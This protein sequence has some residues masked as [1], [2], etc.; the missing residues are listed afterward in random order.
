MIMK[1]IKEKENDFKHITVRLEDAIEA[2]NIKKD[3]IYVDCTFGRGGHSSLILQ[4]LETGKLFCFDQDDEAKK[5][6]YDNFKNKNCFF[7]NSNFKNLKE[8][9]NKKNINYVDG[10]LFDLGVSSPMFDNPERGFSYKYD[11]PLDMRMNQNQKLTAYDVINFYPK[12][13][14]IDIFKKY[15][16]IYNSKH[17]V[18]NICKF[19][20]EKPISTTL[21]LVEIIRQK[22]PIKLQYEKKHFARKYFQAIRIE[23]NDEIN[24][25]SQALNDALLMLNKKGRIVTISF[26]SLEEK[27]IKEIINLNNSK[28]I[29]PKEIPINNTKEFNIIKIKRRAN[30]EELKENRRSRSSFLKVVERQ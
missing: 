24:V 17:V 7:I 27:M 15:G 29:L 22:T 2:L 23:V 30:E 18:D 19:R 11:G 28:N 8:E 3:G 21:E 6:F 14:L 16:D 1:S 26:H 25:L 10:F 20:K 12:E 4:K 9:L 5:F 13:K